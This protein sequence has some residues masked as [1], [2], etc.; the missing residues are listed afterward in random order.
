M[1]VIVSIFAA[2]SII[3]AIRSRDR[4]VL[5]V[6]LAFLPIAIS[7]WLMLDRYSITRFSIGYCPMFAILAA[8]SSDPAYS[9]STIRPRVTSRGLSSRRTRSPTSTRM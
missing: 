7:A 9:F 5:Y 1:N 4:R 2:I 3:G 6:T 8:G